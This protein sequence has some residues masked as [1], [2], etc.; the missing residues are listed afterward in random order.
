MAAASRCL[1]GPA[2]R[3]R[4]HPERGR[5]LRRPLRRT[6]GA[7]SGFVA[8][9][10]RPLRRL[11]GDRAGRARLP[12]PDALRS[13][14][15]RPDRPRLHHRQP[16]PRARDEPAARPRPALRRATAC[17]P[18]LYAYQYRHRRP[19][20][21]LPDADRLLL[22]PQPG[23]SPDPGNRSRAAGG[24]A[25]E[26][27]AAGDRP[28]DRRPPAGR[29]H[30]PRRHPARDRHA[31]TAAGLRADVGLGPGGELREPG[32]PRPHGAAAAGLHA[33]GRVRRECS[34]ARASSS[35]R[36]GATCSTRPT[37]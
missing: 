31:A 26:A 19:D 24:A 6:N 32:R 17:G 5:I 4:R 33:A 15:P 27:V 18:P 11:L 1:G 25:L 34:S 36:S 37:W 21:A 8:A 3:L 2:R 13:L 35:V 29:R 9:T 23:R 12:R 22:L 30:E 16:R 28:R 7:F 20:R 14:L 10:A